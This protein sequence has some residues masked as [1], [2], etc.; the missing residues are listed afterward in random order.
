MLITVNMTSDLEEF[1]FIVF[2]I[3]I[4]YLKYISKENIL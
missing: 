1:I 4:L 3:I 2:K